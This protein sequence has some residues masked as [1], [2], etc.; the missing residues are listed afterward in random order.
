MAMESRQVDRLTF[1]AV[2]RL[3]A[4]HPELNVDQLRA[5]VERGP[6]GTRRS[7]SVERIR[8]RHTGELV[9]LVEAG[10]L[11]KAEAKRY[12]D[13]PNAPRRRATRTAL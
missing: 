11:S 5:L 1:E 10:L 7:R 6:S 2:M 9:A 4:D 8:P 13:I 12:L 3:L